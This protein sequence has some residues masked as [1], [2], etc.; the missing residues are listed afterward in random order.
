MTRTRC[1]SALLC[2]L[3]ACLPAPAQYDPPNAKPPDKATQDAILAKTRQLG[4]ML[5]VMQR[6][7]VRD[8]VF[9]EYI[10][11]RYN[12]KSELTIE[13][14]PGAENRFDFALSGK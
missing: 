4:Q 13:I 14:A 11:A 12:E 5:T 7:G 6:Q 3:A 2:L 9:A 1:F 8:P 10:P